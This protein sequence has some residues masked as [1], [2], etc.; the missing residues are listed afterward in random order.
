MKKILALI[1][2]LVCVLTLF[3]GC[4]QQKTLIMGTSA[5]FPPYEF[6]DTDGSVTGIDADI[7]KAIADE[8]GYKLEIKDMDFKALIPAVQS[9]SI[10]IVLAGMTVTEERKQNVNFSDSYATGKQVI[11]VNENSAIK[12]KDDLKG[13]MIGVQAGTT[14]DIYCTEDYGQDHVKQYKHG[15]LAVT[16][17]KQNQVDCVVTDIDPAKQFVASNSGLKILDVEYITENYAI[18]ISKSDTELLEKI[19][20]IIADKKADGSLQKIID[21][22]ITAE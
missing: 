9:G 5:G 10:D 11:I 22:Y 17:L 8:L 15:T 3:A 2:S 13:K 14:G 6:A 21:K 19:N 12:T 18:A 1:L 16:A 7:A 20:K 4:N